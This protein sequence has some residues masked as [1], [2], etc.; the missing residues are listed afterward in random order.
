MLYSYKKNKYLCSISVLLLLN[1]KGTQIIRDE[2]G[3]QLL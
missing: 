1:E 2:L 3:K